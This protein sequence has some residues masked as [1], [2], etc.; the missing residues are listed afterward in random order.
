MQFSRF[1]SLCMTHMFRIFMPSNGFSR[2]LKVL[3]IL[4]YIFLLLLL[5]G[6]SLIQ[7]LIGVVALTLIDLPLAITFFSVTI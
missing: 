1:V 4:G 5:L 2:M 7:M 6:S 3:L